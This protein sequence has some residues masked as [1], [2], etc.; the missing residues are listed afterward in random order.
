MTITIWLIDNETGEYWSWSVQF[1]MVCFK[2][3]K[4]EDREM[5][6]GV[7]KTLVR[8]KWEFKG[9]AFSNK[10]FKDFRIIIKTMF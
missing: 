6:T 7:W 4:S 3:R 5:C 2:I 8:H 10:E 9:E 1:L